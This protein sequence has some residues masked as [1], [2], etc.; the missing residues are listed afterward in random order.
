MFAGSTGLTPNND[1][2][3][4]TFNSISFSSGA[5]AFLLSG[6]AFTIKGGVSAITANN[7][8]GTM[9]I[10]NNISFSTAAPT[11]TTT[12][13][14]TLNLTGNID[15]GGYI[16]TTTCDG[17]STLS[18]ILSGSG[19]LTKSGSG[20]LTLSG[21]NTY[22]GLTTVSTGI[23]K[24][25]N[26]ASLGTTAAGTTVT[27]GA[28]IDLN[29]VN[30]STTEALTIN[31]TGISTGGALINSNVS[32]ATFAGTITLGLPTKI[33]TTNQITISGDILSSTFNIDKAGTNSLL[34][35]NNSV[36]VKDLTI[37]EG[38]I[39]AGTSNLNI[40]GNF[41]NSGIFTPNNCTVSL[42]G[43]LN[44]V[45]PAVTFKSITLNNSAGASLSGNISVNGTL[46][47]SSGIL[48]TGVYSIDLG[49]TGSIV[50]ATPNAKAPTS[51]VTGAV[52]AT[53]IL[54]QNINN[55]FG[56]I[57]V[58]LTEAN[59]TN[60]ST[61]VI[62]TTG[63][64][65]TGNGKTGI[66]RYFTITPFTDAGLNGTMVFHY[67]DNE[68]VG[69]TEADMKL[70]KSE[71]N[72]AHW[73]LQNASRIDV[74]NNKL[75]LSLISSFS[76]WT[77]SDSVTHN[78]PIVLTKFNAYKKSELV[79]LSWETASE[80]NN[81]YFTLEKSMDGENWNTLYTCN[82][83]G[84]STK[85]HNYLFTDEEPFN[86]TNYYRLKQTDFNGDFAYSKIE[87]VELKNDSVTFIT[88]PNPAYLEE[89]T[90]IVKGICV[91]TATISI[92]DLSG[93]S[94]CSGSVEISKSP[95]K[96]KLSDLCN[97]QPGTYFITIK[98]KNLIQNKRIVIK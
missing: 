53:R 96:I 30:Y 50:E 39:D 26:T 38:T 31:G 7:T 12:S 18:G 65:C 75:T 33:T 10:G 64:A 91:E 71:D 82:G 88:Y 37:S 25:N 20:T 78:L 62:R 83:A 1:L 59:L 19:G 24:L 97:L 54:M 46:T 8:T 3:S 27:S 45:I 85:V 5:G 52:K 55:T 56:G 79:E 13:G 70:Y 76:D 94:M 60:N 36:S 34:F 48:T 40:Y 81:D 49:S 92:E 63:T 2:T 6:N 9:T 80:T 72:R 68:I 14:G 11:I 98:G 87:S 35:A 74:S 47:L 77:G 28:V 41:T 86:G 42:M 4:A 73:L 67:F 90:I 16:I 93:R 66:L 44:Q 17:T 23:L 95:I 84:T 51:Y 22:T 43:T 21:T 89:L 32:P 69:H 58:E 57:G 29:G 15:N 61:E